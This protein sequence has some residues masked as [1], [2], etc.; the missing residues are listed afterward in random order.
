MSSNRKVG[1]VGFEAC[2]S[3]RGNCQG[4]KVTNTESRRKQPQNTTNPTW[5]P[6]G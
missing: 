1:L 6:N 5:S 3:L 2:L 4:D